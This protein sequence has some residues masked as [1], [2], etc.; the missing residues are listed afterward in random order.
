MVNWDNCKDI[1]RVHGKMGG[2]A[3]I[4]GTRLRAQTLVDNFE[5]GSSIEEITENW[6]EIP[7]SMISRVIGYSRSYE[8]QT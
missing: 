2:Q 4:K 7:K 1:E 8:P 5:A 3:V 6:P